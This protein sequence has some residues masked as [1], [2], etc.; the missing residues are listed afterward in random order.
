MGVKDKA[1]KKVLARIPPARFGTKVCRVCRISPALEEEKWE[2]FWVLVGA[3]LVLTLQRCLPL[4]PHAMPQLFPP[5]FYIGCLLSSVT[6]NLSA[7]ELL[8]FHR[9][10]NMSRPKSVV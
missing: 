6:W 8:F 7:E 10:P 3:G 5:G 1:F 9:S 2:S 4:L